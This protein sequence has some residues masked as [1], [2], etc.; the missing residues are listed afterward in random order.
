MEIVSRRIQSRGYR[1][2]YFSGR[3]TQRLTCLEKL[4]G[5]PLHSKDSHAAIQARSNKRTV[6][7]PLNSRCRRLLSNRGDQDK[8][9]DAQ[10]DAARSADGI[11]YHGSVLQFR[12]ELVVARKHHFATWKDF[13]CTFPAYG[14]RGCAA[15]TRAKSVTRENRGFDRR[16]GIVHIYF[17]YAAQRAQ[18]FPLLFLRHRVRV[19]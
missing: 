15:L 1:R 12:R 2:Q 9:L 6:C 17:P 11:Q 19:T 4:S 5:L 10:G 3:N 7:G 14:K 13:Q 8:I 18:G 16:R